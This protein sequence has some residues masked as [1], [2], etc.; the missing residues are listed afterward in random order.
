MAFEIID[1]GDNRFLYRCSDCGKESP[2]S[3]IPKHKL[4]PAP[5][6]NCPKANDE[7]RFEMVEILAE[8]VRKEK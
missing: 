6:H 7:P 5:Y 2:L 4:G 8:Q 1:K 3:P